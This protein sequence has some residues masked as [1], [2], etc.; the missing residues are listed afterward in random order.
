MSPWFDDPALVR[1]LPWLLRGLA[2]YSRLVVDRDS[3]LVR[4]GSFLHRQQARLVRGLGL[5]RDVTVLLNNL[6]VHLDPCDPRLFWVLEE[7]AGETAEARLLDRVLGPGD[8]FLDVGANHGGYSL[9]AARRVGPAGRVVAFEPQP[10]LAA[11]VRRSF[12]SNGFYHASV[13]EIACSD[14]AG[15]ADL[16]VPRRNSGEA[17]IHAA[18]AGNLAVESVRIRLERLDDALDWRAL[19][20]RVVVK[21][22]VEGSEASLLAGAEQ[23]LRIRRPL[24]LFE[25]SPT[26][27]RAAGSSVA[28]VVEALRRVGYKRLAE[29]DDYP[30]TFPAEEAVLDRQRNLVAVPSAV[31]AP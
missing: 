11:L 3:G 6:A 17:S 2:A 22:D 4:G 20:G 10:R 28:G 27:A 5:P 18:L 12:Q 8:T 25:S 16:F 29:V 15:E 30:A 14:R 19:P 24:V 13:L 31:G 1:Q 9:R 26:T 7:V 23:L 21:I